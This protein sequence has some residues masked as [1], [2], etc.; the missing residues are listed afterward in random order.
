MRFTGTDADIRLD[1]DPHPEFD[2]WRWTPLSDLPG[3]ADGFKRPIYDV[4][5]ASFTHIAVPG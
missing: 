4:L 1:L 3:L 5:A 2:A